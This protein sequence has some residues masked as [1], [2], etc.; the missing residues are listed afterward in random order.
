MTT[1]SPFQFRQVADSLKACGIDMATRQIATHRANG[2]FS[3]KDCDALLR[4]VT[5][6]NLWLY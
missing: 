5:D 6:S 4:V 2:D 1:L 3:D